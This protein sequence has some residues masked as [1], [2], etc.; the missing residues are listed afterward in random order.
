MNTEKAAR[1]VGTNNIGSFKK[2]GANAY[3]QVCRKSNIA[4][5]I[6]AGIS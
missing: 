3:D 6:K 1:N 5:Y 2:K 4:S